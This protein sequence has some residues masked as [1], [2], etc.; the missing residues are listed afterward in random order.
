MPLQIF[1]EHTCTCN[2]S[3]LQRVEPVDDAPLSSSYKR[4]LL[5]GVLRRLRQPLQDSTLFG[6]NYNMFC[7]DRFRTVIQ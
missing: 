3:I 7:L 1:R 5:I 4:R 2:T 6:Q